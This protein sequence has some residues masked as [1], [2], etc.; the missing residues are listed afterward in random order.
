MSTAIADAIAARA[1]AQG[2]PDGLAERALAVRTP[3]RQLE[4][5]LQTKASEH[6]LFQVERTIEV[7]ERLASGPYRAR[8]LSYRDE[9][10]FQ[11]LWANAPEKAGEWEVTIERSPNALAQF[12]LQPGASISVIEAGGEL[13]A[14]TVWSPAN[15][16][17]GG[18]PVSIHYAQGLRVRAHR[19]REGLGD[20]VRRFPTRALQNPTLGQVMYLRIGNAN[21][22]GFLEAVKFQADA[23][24]PQKV[25]AAAYLSARP[26]DA[27]VEGLRLVEPRDLAHC[28]ELINRTHDGLDLFAPYGPESLRNVLDGG[29]WGEP[30][31]WR[32]AVYGWADFRVIE[33]KGRIVA[34]GGLWDRG[35]DMR[36]VWRS[37]AGE[38]RRVEVA[39]ALDLGCE[40]GRE[41]ALAD[42]LRDFASRA[43]ALGRQSLI[44]DLEHL[45]GVTARLGD[46]EL[47]WESR[48]LEWSPYLPALPR[49]LG[50]CHLDLRYW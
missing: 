11:D 32:P 26:S 37:T 44:A 41:D 3:S 35:R 42:L 38:E 15:C 20:L 30:P 1:K 29:V 40:A 49:T 14:C 17:I 48:T 22:A 34:C 9:E 4:Q 5:W 47:R 18:K 2:W 23:E 31:P 25:V 50:E 39:A 7:F 33:Q 45:P 19:R 10:A 13:V 24:R 6:H 12:R 28:A 21:M 16:M 43:A 27:S 8:E 46:L 36:E